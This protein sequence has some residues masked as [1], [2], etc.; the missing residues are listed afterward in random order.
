MPTDT[1][2]AIPR[3]SARTAAA[4]AAVAVVLLAACGGGGTASQQRGPAGP[5]PVDA[6]PVVT[7]SMPYLIKAI[8]TVVTSS[9]VAVKAQVGGTL[10][11]VAF[12]E[13]QD[14]RKHDLL[15]VIDQRPYENAVKEA[16]AALARDRALLAK[17]QSDV[18]RFTALRKDE[19]VTAEQLDQAKADEASLAAS[20]EADRAA[21]ENARLNLEYCTIT[22]PIS[23][24]TGNLLVH[25]GNLVKANSDSA[26]VV[27]NRIHPID[28]RFS[29][30]EARLPGI[31]A[32]MREGSLHVEALPQHDGSEPVEGKLTFV[33]NAVDTATGTIM[34]K[35]SFDNRDSRLW[36]GQFVDVVLTLGIQK[37]AV[38]VPSQAVVRSQ[39]GQYA[40]VVKDDSTVESRDVTVDRTIGQESVI[41]S[42]L[43]PGETVVTDGQLRLTPGAEVTIRS[44]S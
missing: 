13:G 42:G 28:I 29:V 24:R 40:Y 44:G 8:G 16:E 26:L 38:V 1:S 23:G 43:E 2:H 9:T 4:L 32:A 7:K 3:T 14:V 33:D 27:I 30:P 18:K 15:F 36:P 6:A 12:T 34:L 11:R 35:A 31:R 10:E 19:F 20:V 5:V 39:S 17:A 21:L 25:E 41:S 22:A 37:D